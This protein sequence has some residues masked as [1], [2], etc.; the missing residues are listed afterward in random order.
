MTKQKSFKAL[1]RARMEKTGESYTSA[2]RNLLAKA[3]NPS[4]PPE[5]SQATTPMVDRF[6]D[7]V[8]HERTGRTWAEWFSLLDQWG[9]TDRNHTEIA[10]WLVN[11][12]HMQG[13][14]AQSVTVA[15]EQARGMR[16][17]GQ[18]SN[19]TFSATASK[20]V[21]VPVMTLFQAFDD[22]VMRRQWLP[23]VN[24]IVRTANAPK[25]FRATWDEGPS[26]VVA[27][28]TAK[29]DSKSQVGLEH[30]RLVDAAAAEQMKAF[31]REQ[32]IT[33]KNL[34]DGA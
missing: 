3:T 27:A 12:Q 10:A 14:W 8:M 20:T 4:S 21:D 32:L 23:D 19:G 33:L 18:R 13:W 28:F 6:A 34:L 30:E 26:R 24:L 9:A 31:W 17:P 11:E 16:Q 7:D 5:R 2:R 1:V 25:S 29:T 22:E 15:Y